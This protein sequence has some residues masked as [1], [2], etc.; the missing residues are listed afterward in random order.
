[1]QSLLKIQEIF[2]KKKLNWLDHKI[3]QKLGDSIPGQ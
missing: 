3:E 2:P 1:M